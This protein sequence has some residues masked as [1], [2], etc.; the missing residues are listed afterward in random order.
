M[1]YGLINAPSVEGWLSALD[2]AAMASVLAAQV[3]VEAGGDLAEIGVWRGKSAIL[4]SLCAR[5]GESVYAVDVFDKYYPDESPAR[6]VKPYADPAL[7]RSNLVAYGRPDAVT[8]V[9]SDTRSDPTLIGRLSAAPIRFFH[10][11]GGHSYNHVVHDCNTALEVVGDRCVVVLDDFMQIENPA[12]TEAVLDTFAGTPNGLVPFAITPKKLYLATRADVPA[13]WRY[14]I[15]LLPTAVV[16]RRQLLN[17]PVVVLN[18]KGFTLERDFHSALLGS[19]STDPT[20]VHTGV[21]ER[22]GTFPRIDDWLNQD[23]SLSINA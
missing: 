15:A 14:L 7:F 21:V 20:N 4:L 2:F 3:G 18:P 6:P 13:Y 10:I 9:A 11:D 5:T 17:A 8:E 1:E 19:A 23:A 16:R 12:V 22:S